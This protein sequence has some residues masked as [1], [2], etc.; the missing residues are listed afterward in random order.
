MSKA[1]PSQFKWHAKKN[2]QQVTKE[3]RKK[4]LYKGEK[5]NARAHT[6]TH[7]NHKYIVQDI[8]PQKWQQRDKNQDI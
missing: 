5:E 6:H 7:K 8:A 2:R 3:E 4:N 1:N